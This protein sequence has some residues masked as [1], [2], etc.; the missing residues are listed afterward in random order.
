MFLIFTLLSCFT[1]SLEYLLSASIPVS[2]TMILKLPFLALSSRNALLL[3][4]W[5]LRL[6]WDIS[7]APTLYILE[8]NRGFL[9]KL[10]RL[11]MFPFWKNW[12]N[13]TENLYSKFVIYRF[14]LPL[15]NNSLN[16][17]YTLKQFPEWV[18]S[19]Q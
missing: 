13:D 16:E 8:S 9:F 11:L 1:L 15:R 3:S 10:C 5:L 17:N 6:H 7:K 14:E 19:F 2:R 4:T 18:V 12:H